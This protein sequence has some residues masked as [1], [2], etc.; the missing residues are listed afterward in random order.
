MPEHATTERLL[1]QGLRLEDV[2]E[3][4]DSYAVLLKCGLK[5]EVRL[6]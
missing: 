1:L 4:F 3:I 5:E 6:D 2:Q